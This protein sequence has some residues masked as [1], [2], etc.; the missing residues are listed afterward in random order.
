MYDHKER[1]INVKQYF[2]VD[3]HNKV[4]IVYPNYETKVN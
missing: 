1:K 3:S 4:Q 2:Y